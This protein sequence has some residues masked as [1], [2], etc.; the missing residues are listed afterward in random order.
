[1]PRGLGTLR[2]V[3]FVLTMAVATAAVGIEMVEALAIVLAVGVERRIRDAL[4]GARQP[5]PLSRCARP[6]GPRF[7]PAPT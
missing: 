4:I 6:W 5:W 3:A 7:C 2:R 1:M